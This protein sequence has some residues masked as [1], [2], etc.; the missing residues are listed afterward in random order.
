MLLC[1]YGQQQDLR[2]NLYIA[3]YL[4]I[5]IILFTAQKKIAVKCL[6]L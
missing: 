6:L 3:T 1:S 2:I 4:E 5:R